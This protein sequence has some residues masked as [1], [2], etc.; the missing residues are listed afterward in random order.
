VKAAVPGAKIT[1]GTTRTA[2]DVDSPP[3][4]IAR[5]KEDVGFTP[6]YDLKR[7][8]KAYVDWLIDGKY[9]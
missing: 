8:V 1:L 3:I 5:L 4:S 7:G 2:R 6:E 9:N